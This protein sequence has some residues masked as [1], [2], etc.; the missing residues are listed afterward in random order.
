MP[1]SNSQAGRFDGRLMVTQT[2]AM[3][4]NVKPFPFPPAIMACVIATSRKGVK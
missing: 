1:G 4:D 3:A 2:D